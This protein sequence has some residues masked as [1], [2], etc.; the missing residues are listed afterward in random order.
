MIPVLTYHGVNI[1]GN[2]Y[3]DNDH[4]ALAEDLKLV[5]DRGL[6]ILPL[7][8]VVDWVRGEVDDAAVAGGV[9]LTFDDGAW[10][11][12]YDLDHPDCGP[13]RSLAGI[14]R[15][16][17]LER[18]VPVHATSFV[19]ASP[20]ARR[21][22]DRTCLV[23]RGWWNDRWW[24]EAVAEGLLDLG[25]HSWDHLHATLGRVAHSEN[26]RDDFSRVLTRD[27][28][29]AQIARAGEYIAACS[30]TRPAVFA[31]PCGRYNEYLVREYLPMR[32]GEL[33]LRGAVTT[34][35]RAVSRDDDPWALPRFTCGQDW[36][37]PEGLARILK[38]IP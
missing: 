35:P 30:G 37:A 13:Q 11:D 14:L 23:G 25:N 33:G 31:Y 28:A 8:T 5:H 6:R 34:E 36:H 19:I 17:G 18:A 3:A 27:D 15:D 4:V 2:D 38:D 22:L 7:V 21:E 20:Q 12:W 10:F 26:V 24:P 29:E 9:A 16:F 32:G 1:H